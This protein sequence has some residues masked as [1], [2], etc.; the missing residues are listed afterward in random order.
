[1]STRACSS[2]A[3]HERFAT[4][5]PLVLAAVRRHV[6]LAQE[7]ETP[8]V[9]DARSRLAAACPAL[10][11]RELDVRERLL[12]GWSHDGIA[13]DLESSP[14][15]RPTGR[16]PS[17]AWACISA[18]SCSP[19]STAREVGSIVDAAAAV[20][21]RHRRI[22]A[23]RTRAV[24]GNAAQPGV[25]RRSAR[26]GHHAGRCLALLDPLTNVLTMSKR[27]VA[28]PPEQ[29]DMPGTVNSRLKALVSPLP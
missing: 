10:T 21:A 14:R 12:R 6:A 20:V 2:P 27:S 29:C 3:E 9:I 11:A 17:S 4:M 28:G 25:E 8:R 15:S 22:I 18:A 19:A 5:A 16:G 24:G 23:Q 7:A 1:M 26:S 13:A